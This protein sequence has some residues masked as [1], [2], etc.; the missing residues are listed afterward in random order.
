MTT[1]GQPPTTDTLPAIRAR[2]SCATSRC[3]PALDRRAAARAARWRWSS[4]R[5]SRDRFLQAQNL[6]LVLQQVMV[7]GVLA[8]GQTLII[9]TAGIDLSVRRR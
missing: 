2:A 4:S 7:V 1:T 5:S 3:S 6:S 9:L 8:I